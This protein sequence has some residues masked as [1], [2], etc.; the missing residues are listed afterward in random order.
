ML[1]FFNFIPLCPSVACIIN[2]HLSFLYDPGLEAA[3]EMDI[4]FR[5]FLVTGVHPASFCFS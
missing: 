5:R 2:I 4:L 3:C 1:F